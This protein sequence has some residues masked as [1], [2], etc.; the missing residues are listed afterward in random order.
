MKKHGRYNHIWL[1]L[2]LAATVAI[3]ACAPQATQQTSRAADIPAA[4]EQVQQAKMLPVGTFA[5][6]VATF[7]EGRFVPVVGA[8]VKV[9]GADGTAVT[10]VDGQYVFNGL[11]PGDY[12]VVVTKDGFQQGEGEVKLSPVAGTPRVNVAMNKPSYA[13]NQAAITPFSAT[14]TGVVTD[15]R[16][17]A[18]PNATV[19][20]ATTAGTG[21]NQIVPANANGFYTV[22]VANMAA[23][24][25][26]PGYIQVTAFGTTP[27]GV[28]VE[29]DKVWAKPVTSASLVV[30][31]RCD[32]FT[33]PQNMT[34]PAGT[35]TPM[36][37]T[38]A[39]ID[40]EWMSTRADEFY[41]RLDYA[42]GTFAVL[43]E[44]ITNTPAVDPA[45]QKCKIKY[46]VPFTFPP[47]VSTY[48]I[49]VVPFGINTA[50]ADVTSDTNLVV[51]YTE[52]NFSSDIDYQAPHTLVDYTRGAAE[53]LPAPNDVSVP[54][55][56]NNGK[57]V[58]GENAL[59]RLTITNENNTI[60][61]DLRVKGTA[62]PGSTIAS[63]KVITTD[64]VPAVPVVTTI[65]IPPAN[66]VG[67]DGSGNFTVSGFTIPK[68][69]AAG[70]ADALA[71][72]QITFASPATLAPA[73]T[74]SVSA[75]EVG[76][77]SAGHKDTVIDVAQPT[78][79]L[80]ASGIDRNALKFDSV[81]KLIAAGAANDDG[82]ALVTLT[83]NPGAGSNAFGAIKITDVTMTNRPVP[84]AK[85]T[86]TGTQVLPADN[87]SLGLRGSG[88]PLGQD[89]LGLIVDGGAEKVVP[90][91]SDACDL[92]TLNAF[93]NGFV[94]GVTATRDSNNRIK[95]ERNTAGGAPL[96]IVIGPSTTA[97]TLTRLGFTSA[98]VAVAGSNGV[99]AR[100]ETDGAKPLNPSIT[101]AGAAGAAWEFVTAS[102]TSTHAA[103]GALTAN[104]VIRPVIPAVPPGV[105]D[106]TEVIT[107]NYVIEQMG[108]GTGLNLGGG[109]AA[110]GARITNINQVTPFTVLGRDVLIN[111]VNGLTK[112]DDGALNVGGGATPGL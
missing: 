17:A 101:T 26:S 107:I 111:S 94:T 78:V 2:P 45:P 62:T 40:V 91:P 95:I 50:A 59:Y 19:R 41:L 104:F 72:V 69:S 21:T 52:A 33:L 47:N 55:N 36:G 38:N 32:A 16:G 61:P 84:A 34:H 71:E 44:S 98:Q 9:E 10:D 56:V 5:G 74:F 108:G 4:V 93:I 102:S 70:V 110:M 25:I 7:D 37:A 23:S 35:F 96:N 51:Q 67:P 48:K 109:G 57:F 83:I 13:L 97:N 18:L 88:N 103:G 42:G 89:Q 6:M 92:I 80:T 8:T 77:P 46:R 49:Y 99:Q 112:I 14:V 86:L 22:T 12:K 100:F 39:E 87:T 58:A 31:A 15:P 106:P 27:G 90:I 30:N 60:A 63:A 11:K 85:A 76:M 20:V 82:Y 66:I 105:Y 29:V 65:N 1:A 73:G 79:S 68:S 43:P 24:P 28:K 54:N 81:T 64:P 3:T 53:A 75:L